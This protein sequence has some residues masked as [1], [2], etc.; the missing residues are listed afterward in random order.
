M[1]RDLH[2]ARGPAAAFFAVGLFWGTFAALVPQLKAQVGLSDGGFGLA[3][4][5]ASCGAILAMWLAPLAERRL[6]LRAM[7]VLA[8]A[9]ALVFLLPGLA[10]TGPGFA[11]AMMGGAMASGTLDVVMNARVSVLEGTARRSLMNLCH[12]VFSVGYA[13][14]ALLGGLGRE[15]GL[16]PVAIFAVMSLLTGLLI[17]Q[18]IAAPVPDPDRD[19]TAPPAAAPS[20]GLLAPVG[21]IILVAFL[22][23]QGTEGWSALHL[24]RNLGAG[25][26][27]GALGP[28]ILGL[29]MAVGRFSGQVIAQRFTEAAVIRLAAALTAAGALT[30]AWATALPVAYAGFAMLGLGVSVIAPMAFAWIGRLVAPE[31]KALAIS[32]VAVL[33]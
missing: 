32:R 11:L 2:T 15:V 30:A 13:I 31:R 21:L 12:G 5:V 8:G 1:L 22:A 26:A 18:M 3:M 17:L 25:A 27:M 23:E 20:W 24:E 6:G 28:A 10:V 33:G 19:E 14:A 9:M 7:P 29:T 4:L 16:P